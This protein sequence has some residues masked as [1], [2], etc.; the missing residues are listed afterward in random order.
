MIE[1]VTGG[2][3]DPAPLLSQLREKFGELYELGG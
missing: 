1:R 3:L 2:P